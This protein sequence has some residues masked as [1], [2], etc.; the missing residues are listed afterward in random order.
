MF[1][2]ITASVFI[3]DQL[4]KFLVSTNMSWN[5]TVELFP[6]VFD[7]TYIRNTG[8]AFGIF[9]GRIFLLSAV[10]AVLLIGLCVYAVS[11]RNK[12]PKLESVSLALIVG[13]GLGNLVTRLLYNYV[14]DFFNF[15]FWPVFN[16]ADI[17]ICVGCGF[18]ILSVLVIEPKKQK[19]R[20][21]G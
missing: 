17:A 10:T 11:Q 18:L 13:G 1:V 12:I 7:L 4:S 20:N 3:V 16:V 6:G 5:Q 15:Y 2:I 19:Q 14:I 21:N 8:A 9:E